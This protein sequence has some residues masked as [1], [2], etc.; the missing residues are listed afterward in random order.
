M[1]FT[2]S[3]Q[4]LLKIAGLLVFFFDKFRANRLFG[5]FVS[6]TVFFS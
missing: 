1:M 3:S 4:R 2:K 6:D 5:S